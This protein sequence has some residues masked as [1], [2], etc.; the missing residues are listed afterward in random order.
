MQ[1]LCKLT[2]GSRYFMNVDRVI[3]DGV[4]TCTSYGNQG[5]TYQE[6]FFSLDTSRPGTYTICPNITSTILAHMRIVLFKQGGTTEEVKIDGDDIYQFTISD[7]G[8]KMVNF[9]IDI[10]PT[11]A[12]T[13]V[14]KPM[15]VPLSLSKANFPLWEPYKPAMNL[16]D[17]SGFTTRT[18]DTI[19]V[20]QTS[21]NYIHIETSG[22]TTGAYKNVVLLK[23][24][25]LRKVIH[26]GKSYFIYTYNPNNDIVQL[27]INFS[28]GDTPY[29]NLSSTNKY[30]AYSLPENAVLFDLLVQIDPKGSEVN[31]DI[32]VFVCEGRYTPQTMPYFDPYRSMTKINLYVGC[33][34][35]VERNWL[36]KA[37]GDFNTDFLSHYLTS[38]LDKFNYIKH[39]LNISVKIPVDKNG[40]DVNAVYNYMSIMNEGDEYPRYYFIIN[41]T[42]LSDKTVRFDLYMDTIS[43]FWNY[44]E[45]TDRCHVQR[46]M[47]DRFYKRDYYTATVTMLRDI[48]KTPEGINPS[49]E[50]KSAKE[51]QMDP[52][53]TN[54]YLIYK[55]PDDVASDINNP[56]DVL[57]CADEKLPVTIQQ[58][59]PVIELALT[60]NYYYYFWNEDTPQGQIQDLDP[61][62]TVES[63]QGTL[64]MYVAW[65]TSNNPSVVNIARV[66]QHV[67]G[68]LQNINAVGS[69]TGKI[70]LNKVAAYRIGPALNYSPFYVQTLEKTYVNSGTSGSTNV[71][72]YS[73]VNRTDQRLV[74][75]I[76]LP[77]CPVACTIDDDGQYSFGDNWNLKSGLV[78]FKYDIEFDNT[79]EGKLRFYDYLTYTIPSDS[80]SEPRQ[81]TERDMEAE[82]KLYNSEFY[83]FNI[84]YADTYTTINLEQ[85]K[86]LNGNAGSPNPTLTFKAT[87]TVNSNFA[88]GINLVT[89]K[90]MATDYWYEPSNLYENYLF[91][92]RNNEMPIYNNAW[93]DY[94]NSGNYETDRTNFSLASAQ[95]WISLGSSIGT[96]I[97]GVAISSIGGGVGTAGVGAGI[98]I[99]SSL[100]NS[101]LAQVEA[102][103]TLEQ[104]RRDLQLQAT[105]VR[106]STDVDLMSWYSGNK[107]VLNINEP[108]E[109][110]K[111]KLY[112]L[113]YYC[114]YKTDSM[115]KPNFTTR[116]WFDYLEFT[117]DFDIESDG[118]YYAKYAPYVDDIV[119]RCEKGLTIFHDHRNPDGDW[120]HKWQISQTL[121]NWETWLCKEL[122]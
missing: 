35:T 113:F 49:F 10:P 37:S 44:F 52:I 9:W 64:I 59:G 71:M 41:R 5:G 93:I 3:K 118:A 105:S 13:V 99:G 107:L 57:L 48:N 114:G 54:W 70:K 45:F 15:L 60:P 73:E 82:S 98:G 67:D 88:F 51:I 47:F 78:K 66:Y 6:T 103:N 87:N 97:L 95:R 18:S 24:E 55:T 4:I 100:I 1:N 86:F 116:W 58:E 119:K 102:S 101:I 2:N 43:T 91:I 34:L 80:S 7:T 27:R 29:Y 120:D 77:Y 75:I 32:Y 81:Y 31:T 110:I 94:V 53:D 68:I 33:P 108:D 115:E 17:L 117:P 26:P 46:K 8:T 23:A 19:T 36:M 109:V 76:K 69:T 42:I 11:Q 79:R 16:I 12:G 106:G 63:A 112:D 21:P 121:E 85:F 65:C 40:F 122:N 30:G 62:G 92:N 89:D 111:S 84:R 61:L 25:D 39:D 20:T 50:F 83:N 72:S 38:S 96:N 74:K 22:P 104:K 56:L 14:Y 90:S 28:V